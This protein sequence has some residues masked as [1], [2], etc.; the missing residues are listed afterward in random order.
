MYNLNK[1]NGFTLIELLVVVVIIGILAAVGVVTF[2]GYTEDAKKNLT[3][4]NY[5]NASKFIALTF[6]KCNLENYVTV[7]AAKL[8]CLSE[9]MESDI[10][11]WGNVLSIYFLEQGFKNP[12]DSDTAGVAVIRANQLKNNVNGTLILSSDP[13]TYGSGSRLTLSYK[14]PDNSGETATFMLD[15]WCK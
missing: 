5:K 6:A 8:N 15:R 1:K 2:S 11:S 7:G 10:N 3:I 9:N 14:V 4:S 13:C 12:Y